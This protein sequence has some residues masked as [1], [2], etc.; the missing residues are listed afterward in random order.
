MDKTLHLLKKITILVMILALPGFL[1]YLLTAEGKNRY[2]PLPIYGPKPLAKTSHIV[3][4]KAIPDTIYHTL[5]DFNLKDQ[6]GRE[7]SFKTFANKILVVN[8]FYSGCGKVGNEVNA[9]ADSLSS[10]YAKNKIVYFV[11][12]TVNPAADSVAALKKYAAGFKNAPANRLFLTGDTA[13]IYTLSGKGMLVDAMQTGKNDFIYSNDLILIDS[14]KR[15]RGYYS[16]A[17]VDDVNRLNDEIKVLI[18]EE[19]R[20]KDK[21]LY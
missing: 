1:Y 20:K 13:T 15:I 6:Y 7:V 8:F 10:A 11:S 19:L 17:S 3:K 21:P 18:A 12:I 5:S 16:G 14:E 2:K 9:N 4:G